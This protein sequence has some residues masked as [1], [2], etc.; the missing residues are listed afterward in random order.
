MFQNHSKLLVAS[1]AF[2]VIAACSPQKEYDSFIL[3]QGYIPFQQ[4]LADIG[5]GTLLTG[6][7]S[8][9]RIV[10]PKQRCFPESYNGVPTEIRHMSDADL[11]EIAKKI[12]LDAGVDANVIAA[13]GTPLFKLNAK[14]TMLK[15]LDVHIEGASVEYLD[16]L[17][18]SEWV[19]SAMSAS[20]KNYLTKGGS[21][22]RQALRVD[23]MSFQFKNQT[24]GLIAISVDN[25]KDI[26]DL[27]AHVKWDISDNYTLTINT[28]KYIG[29]HLAKV[30]AKD[31]GSI[32]WIASGLTSEGQFDYKPVQGYRILGRGMMLK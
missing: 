9:L 23:K 21:F 6:S 5:V 18:F 25:I 24:G 4:P 26:I 17:I 12:S 2:T 29:Y 32:A 31:P 28:P 15:S 22:I 8:Q 7:P 10:A 11:P 20:C 1:L 27:E 3:K 13:N 16:E 30:S 19:N 14:F